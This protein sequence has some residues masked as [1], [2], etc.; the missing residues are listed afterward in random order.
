METLKKYLSIG[1]VIILLFFIGYCFLLNS[2]LENVNTKLQEVNTEKDNL[3]KTNQSQQASITELENSSKSNQAF[4][5][6]KEA[7]QLK[8]KQGASQVKAEYRKATRES[9]AI[10]EWSRVPLPPDLIK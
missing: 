3:I 8:T 5:Q 2:R 1:L 7:K 10:N 4:I 9:Q 6:D